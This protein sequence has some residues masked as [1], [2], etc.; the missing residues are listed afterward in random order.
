MLGLGHW[1]E[2]QRLRT[3]EALAGFLQ[4]RNLSALC[5]VFG[6]PGCRVALRS[7]SFGFLLWFLSG[8]RSA[9]PHTGRTL[10]DSHRLLAVKAA[11]PL[12]FTSKVS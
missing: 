4:V 7:L 12:T 1:E 6:D 5:G 11:A 8:E 3:G 9:E 2:N 10:L